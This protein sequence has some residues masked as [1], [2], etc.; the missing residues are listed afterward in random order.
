MRRIS[1]SQCTKTSVLET[2]KDNFR[3]TKMAFQKAKIEKN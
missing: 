3:S 2:D 1:Y